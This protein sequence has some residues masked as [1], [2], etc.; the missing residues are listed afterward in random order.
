MVKLKNRD[1]GL[2][3]KELKSIQLKTKNYSVRTEIY[4]DKGQAQA[5]AK[6][7]QRSGLFD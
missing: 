5:I 6:L 4:P 2:H 3:S 7:R 1:W